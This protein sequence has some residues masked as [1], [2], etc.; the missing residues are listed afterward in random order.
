MNKKS[1]IRKEIN[2]SNFTSFKE[3]KEEIIYSCQ[4]ALAAPSIVEM[5]KHALLK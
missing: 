2:M 4:K 3:K 1:Y 5:G